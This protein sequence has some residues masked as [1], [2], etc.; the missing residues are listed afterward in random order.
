MIMTDKKYLSTMIVID[1]NICLPWLIMT[2]LYLWKYLS[3]RIAIDKIFVLHY[4][5][6]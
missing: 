3:A 4:C 5:D 2:D 1:N 6:C